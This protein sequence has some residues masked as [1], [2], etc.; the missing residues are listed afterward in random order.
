MSRQVLTNPRATRDNCEQCRRPVPV[1]YCSQIRGR[2]K[3][4]WPVYIV[5]DTRESD[6]AIG[7][8]RIA[9]LSLNNCALLSINPDRS[10]KSSELDALRQL[11]PALIYPGE[12]AGNVSGLCEVPKTPLLFIDASWR[13]SRKILLTQPWIAALPRYSLT[14]DAPSR[15]RIR[16]QPAPF[17]LSTLEAIVRT[18]QQLEPDPARFDSLISTMDWVVD[19]QIKYMGNSTW[20]SNYLRQ[21]RNT[22]E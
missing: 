11:Q 3:N 2:Q 4:S 6:H 1:C 21:N 20:R 17:A 9:A 16:K 18:L 8:A 14:V 15:Y 22:N 19:Q 12:N 7:T 13:R 10:T 5:Q